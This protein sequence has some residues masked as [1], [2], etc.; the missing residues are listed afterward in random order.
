VDVEATETASAP[1]SID[2]ITSDAIGRRDTMLA[3]RWMANVTLQ[4]MKPLG[5]RFTT[6]PSQTNSNQ[7]RS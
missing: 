6:T 7:T 1:P 3:I 2:V 4:P 5:D